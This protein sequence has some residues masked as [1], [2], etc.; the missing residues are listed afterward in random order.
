MSDEELQE[1]LNKSVKQLGESIKEL[2]LL[3]T[4]NFLFYQCKKTNNLAAI[5][6]DTKNII[7]GKL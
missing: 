1:K 3:I 4:Q 5:I 6:K 2:K 7:G